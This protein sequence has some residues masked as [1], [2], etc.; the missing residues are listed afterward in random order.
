MDMIINYHYLHRKA[1]CSYSFG[2]LEKETDRMIGVVIYGMP[3]SHN[4]CRGICGEEES[5]NVIE[6]TRLWIED[7]TPKNVESFLV[8]N[9]IKKINKE[10]IIS[11]S[12]IEQ[13]H[14]GTVYQATNFIYTGLTEK[15]T[16]RIKIDGSNENKHNRH[17]AYD[18][19]DTKLVD[20]PRKHRYIYLNCQKK[21]KN[22]LI[23]KLRY[24]VKAYP[25]K[26]LD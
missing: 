7:S 11:Y 6:L 22:E 1:A 3:A 21:R 26:E 16:N 19:K 8:G 12:E 15:R 18:K 20:R 10:I 4:V 24:E 5:N 14:V 2:L 9:T 13:G 23:K 17:A 25:K